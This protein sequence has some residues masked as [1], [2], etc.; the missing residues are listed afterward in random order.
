MR[1]DR[2]V[3]IVLLLQSHGQL[4]AAQLA[5]T[6]ETSERTIRRDLDALCVSGVPLYSQRGRGG[7]WAIL[8]G[9][10]IDLSGFTA[11]EAR[12]LFM[13]AGTGA[14]SVAAPS[15]RSALRKV[16]AALPEP[17]RHQATAAERSAHVDPTRCG[18]RGA[19]DVSVVAL[20]QEALVSRVQVDIDYVK[21]GA[22]PQWR[23]V[24]PYGLVAK[25]GILYLLAGTANGRR[26]FRVGRITDATLS[27]EPCEIPE[28]FD[29]AGEWEKVQ[30]EFA[31]SMSSVEVRLEVR[32]AAV[33]RLTTVLGGWVTTTEDEPEQAGWRRLRAWFPHVDAAAVNLAP[34]GAD[35]RVESPAELRSELRKIG[36]ALVTSNAERR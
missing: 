36:E 11:E 29:L 19:E 7:G 6:L 1:A 13:M 2:L 35:I 24:S 22:E 33:L 10:R 17:L 21:P 26:T 32:E 15:V 8:G 23:R 31:A 5:E 34:F 12:A 18:G 28:G 20:L 3:A 27:K 25:A 14:G 4:T 9:N 30:S 16:L